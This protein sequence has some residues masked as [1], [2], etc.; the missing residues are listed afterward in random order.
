MWPAG[1]AQGADWPRLAA[2]RCRPR[3]SIALVKLARRH[4]GMFFDIGAQPRAVARAARDALRLLWRF[5]RGRLLA[6]GR[7]RRSAQ[8]APRQDR[9]ARLHPGDHEPLVLAH[10]RQERP[11][12]VRSCPRGL[13]QF[14]C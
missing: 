12:G 4:P 14:S 7:R 1:T 11:S 2:P 10:A 5:R 13:T 9:A 3:H 8:R 6:C